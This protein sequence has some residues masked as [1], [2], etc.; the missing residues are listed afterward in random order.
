MSSPG[1]VS[2]DDYKTVYECER[3]DDYTLD[4]AFEE[5]NIKHPSDYKAR[6]L[7]VSDIVEMDGKSYFC[8]S[9]GWKQVF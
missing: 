9:I 3:D 8:M 6:S 1:E 2:K 7:S 5:F 4:D